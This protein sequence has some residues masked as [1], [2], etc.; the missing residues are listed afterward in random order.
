MAFC[1]LNMKAIFTRF[2]GARAIFVKRF[3]QP[4]PLRLKA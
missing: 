1:G 4:G 3:Q 2:P